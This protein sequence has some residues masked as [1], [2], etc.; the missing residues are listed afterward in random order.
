MAPGAGGN[1]GKRGGS[2]AMA[3]TRLLAD[4]ARPA[5]PAGTGAA[6]PYADAGRDQ[7]DAAPVRRAGRR[8]G[9]I[10]SGLAVPRRRS[11]AGR[12]ACRADAGGGALAA[13][14][15]GGSADAARPDRKS[16]RLN[17]SY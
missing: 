13:D 9:R 12:G 4:A 17:S 7:P 5:D 6:R 2:G 1:A 8:F 3:A 16:T 11:R 10:G 15:G 14:G